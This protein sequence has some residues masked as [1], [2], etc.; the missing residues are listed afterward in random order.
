[1][2]GGLGR[3]R[4]LSREAVARRL[5]VGRQRL[6]RIEHRGLGRLR[7]ADRSTGCGRGGGPAAVTRGG[8]VFGLAGARAVVLAAALVATDGA[9]ARRP[10]QQ[11]AGPKQQADKYRSTFGGR[12]GSLPPVASAPPKEAAIGPVGGSEDGS[13]FPWVILPL[14]LLAA[15]AIVAVAVLGRRAHLAVAGTAAAARRPTGRMAAVAGAQARRPPPALGGCLAAGPPSSRRRNRLDGGAAPRLEGPFGR[16]GIAARHC[17]GAGR[18]SCRGAPHR[19]RVLRRT[20]GSSPRCSGD[21][22]GPYRHRSAPGSRG[23]RRPLTD[24]PPTSGGHDD[25]NAGRPGTADPAHLAAGRAPG[26]GAPRGSSRRGVGPT[27]SSMG[28]ANRGTYRR[29]SGV[30]SRLAGGALGSA[31]GDP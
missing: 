11:L 5:H 27:A 12:S 14:L 26:A 7:R 6:A 1:M 29:E 13:D 9:V 30:T 17:F 31:H 19:A 2:R 25:R 21:N 3:R 22:C 18:P 28:S 24:P 15:S 8:T 4:P 10:A 20:A 16:P 23:R